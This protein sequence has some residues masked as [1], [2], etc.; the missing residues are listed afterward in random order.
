MSISPI[1]GRQSHLYHVRHLTLTENPKFLLIRDNKTHTHDYHEEKPKPESTPRPGA[2]LTHK[3][4]KA[5]SFLR[6]CM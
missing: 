5:S 4:A 2:R 6:Y 3:Q 1:P